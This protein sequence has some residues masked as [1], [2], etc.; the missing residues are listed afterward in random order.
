MQLF[1]LCHRSRGRP[2]WRHQFRPTQIVEAFFRNNPPRSFVPRHRADERSIAQTTPSK[3]P[4]DPPTVAPPIG[5]VLGWPRWG[6]DRSAA[7][8]PATGCWRFH[9]A[10][11]RFRGWGHRMC[12]ASHKASS[13]C[14]RCKGSVDN[15]P[16]LSWLSNHRHR[17]C[18]RRCCR[19]EAG[20]RSPHRSADAVGR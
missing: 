3:Q 17:R 1:C 18:P 16:R 2:L 5:Q 12:R 10:P 7:S 4:P 14:G 8:T 15:D 20:T 11:H 13:V 19:V 9:G 6:V